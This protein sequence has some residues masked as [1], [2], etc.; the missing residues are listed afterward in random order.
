MTEKTENQGNEAQNTEAPETGTPEAGK[1]GAQ[2]TAQ[3]TAPPAGTAAPAALFDMAPQTQKK[4]D[5]KKGTAGSGG[6]NARAKPGTRPE[7]TKYAEGTEIRYGRE[8]LTLPREMTAREALAWL[9]EDDFPEL[10]Y[11]AEAKVVYDK[12]KNRL[13]V[14][15]EAQKKGLGKGPCA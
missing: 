3:A 12:D 15:R 6:P 4:D 13:V 14:T 5:P 1:T 8:K 11:E 10:K 2:A 9:A 7:P